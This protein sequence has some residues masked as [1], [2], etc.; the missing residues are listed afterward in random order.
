M[1]HTAPPLFGWGW[2]RSLACSTVLGVLIFL[3]SLA[4]RD[5]EALIAPAPLPP[6]N[7]AADFPSR[8]ESVTAALALL[9]W[10]LPQPEEEPQ[11]SGALRWTHRRYAL[12]LPAPDRPDAIERLLDPLRS[13]APGVTVHINEEAIGAHV[14]IGIDGLLTH[15]L[16]L[17]W[18]GRRARAA[19]I[20]DDLG[21]DL[22]IARTLVAI[23]A[24]LTLAV[25]PFRPFSKEVAELA[26]LFGREVLLDLPMQNDNGEDF[27]AQRVLL[28][29]ADRDTIVGQIDDSLATVP[30][31]AGVSNHM[32][33]RL[34]ADRVHMLWVLGHLKQKGLFFIDSRTTANSVACD[35]AAALTL[36]CAARSVSLDDTDEEPAIRAQMESVS[37]LARRHG[38]VIAIGHARAATAA[39]LHAALPRVAAAGVEVVPASTIAADLAAWRR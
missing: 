34:T 14:Q 8:I 36:P 30:H 13:A 24:P 18:L 5:P 12:T 22:L 6:G 3:S 11:G 25:M 26:A 37:A 9:P 16:T 23:E 32:G 21:D 28:L 33:S 39:A 4:L 19:I 31:V 2:L 38:A 10:P 35:V 7:W 15:T 17:H 1:S 20:I 27:D 29:G